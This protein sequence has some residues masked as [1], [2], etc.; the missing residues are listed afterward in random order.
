MILTLLN[1]PI[2]SERA[3]IFMVPPAKDNVSL[4]EVLSIIIYFVW[5]KIK[6]PVKVISGLKRWSLLEFENSEVVMNILFI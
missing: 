1:I 4:K 6:P 5:V 2:K 3:D